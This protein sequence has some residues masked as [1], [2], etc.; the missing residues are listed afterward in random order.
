MNKAN[1]TAIPYENKNRY[2]AVVI[3][4]GLS[5]RMGT[6]KP[7][8]D[9]GGKPALYRLLD[10]IKEAGI[11]TTVVVTGFNHSLIEQALQCYSTED[12]RLVT[13]NNQDYKSGMFSSVQAGIRLAEEILQNT[14]IPKSNS[15]AALLFPVDVPLVD[16]ETI[17]G[18][19]CAWE[20]SCPSS[21]DIDNNTAE[22]FAVP[23]YK[24]KNGHPL[25]IPE[26][27]FPEILSYTGEGGLKGVRSKY[28]ESLLRHETND[29]GCFLDMD[30]KEDYE[31]LL[32]FFSNKNN[33]RIFLIRHGQPE[34]HNGKIFLGQADIPLSDLG[35]TEA[36]AA[37]KKLL[38][39]DAKLKRIYTSDLIRASETADIIA[40]TLGGIPVVPDILFRE[41]AMGSWDGELI[42][43][44]KTKFPEEYEKRGN[45][46]RNYR[47]PGGENFYDLKGR[48]TREFHRI[49][50]EDF[51]DAEED[52]GDLV[53]VAHLGVLTV[54]SEEIMSTANF[55]ETR[56]SFST[57]SV[58]K[59]EIPEWMLGE[60][61]EI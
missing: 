49:F 40:E 60:E 16:T 7:L 37:G 30:T 1:K 19:I 47:T 2:V 36:S 39:E 28:D 13:I 6:F 21:I 17:S 18:L 42:E 27:Y 11:A 8:L 50:K 29:Q 14:A 4:A 10:S 24:N 9:I 12:C 32:E 35:K 25:L 15:E 58:T 23:I 61:K 51:R 56:R 54:I 46:L 41:M 53:I 44:I 34:Q 57:G 48:V 43:D 59:Y 31:K 38:A 5:E 45:D 33:S 26:C 52:P 20:K 3:A 22:P 55:E